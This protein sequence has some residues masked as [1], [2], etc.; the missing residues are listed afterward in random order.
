MLVLLFTLLFACVKAPNVET[1]AIEYVEIDSC[2]NI[3]D[4][5]ACNFEAIN[6]LNELVT[7]YELEGRPFILDLSAMW[8]GP[9][10]SAARDVQEIQDAYSEF[11]FVYLTL[12]ID[13][14]QG[15]APTSE[16]L[17]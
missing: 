12:L 4:R 7:L 11:D 16:N 3:L 2:A 15:E 9:C 10:Q 17:S 8:C 13:D 6:D 1:P 5:K 14:A